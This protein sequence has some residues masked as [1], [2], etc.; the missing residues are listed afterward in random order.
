MKLD[1]V[2]TIC[3]YCGT[4]CGLVL[5]V[6][7]GKVI[8]TYPDPEHPVS[9]GT[10]CIKGWS[11]HEFIH[12][13]ERLKMPLL[14]SKGKFQ[15]ISWDQA[16]G[17]GADKLKLVAQE[18]G[19]DAVAGL[20]SAKCT[21]EENYLFQKLIRAAFKT[22]NVDHCARLCHGPT[23][24]AMSE[25]LGS[26]AMTNSIGDFVGADC[27]LMMGSNAA[28]THPI[29]MGEIYK[30]K[31]QGAT[32]IAVDPRQTEVA[33]NADI[34]LDIKPGA[35]IPLVCGMMRHI[36]DNSL[37]ARALISERTEGFEE[38][39]GYLK[40]WSVERASQECGIDQDLLR[41]VSEIYAKANEASIV[42]CMGVTQHACGTANV[43]AICDLAMLC[44][45]VGKEHSGICPLRGQNNVQGACDMGA[46]PNVYPGYQGVSD[47]QVREKFWKA[48]G[49][50][51]LSDKPGLTLTEITGS[52]GKGIRALYIMAEN[53]LLS[54]PDSNHVIE[55]LKKLDFLIVQDI[56]LTE[57]AQIADLVLPGACF[58]EKTGTYTNTE[59]RIQLIRKAIGP[60][61]D[62]KDD[63]TIICMLGKALG[64]DFD[65]AD[66]SDVMDEIAS[67]TYIY[68]GVHFHRLGVNGLQWPCPKDD[69]PGTRFLHK[70]NF[71]RGKGLFVIPEYKPPEEMPDNSYPYILI[72]GRMFSHY[73]TGTMTRRSSF[74]NR[75]V[76]V[77]YVE[78]NPADATKLEIREGDSIRVSTRRGSIV[79]TTRITE[80]VAAGSVFTPF[81]FKEAPANALTIEALDPLSKI[82]EFKLCAANVEK[83]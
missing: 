65:Y 74:L 31:D 7:D 57:T 3:P 17:I 53:P 24:A 72:T 42:F 13:P 23:A 15:E 67:L 18:H 43:F 19:G 2:K 30:A 37:E 83:M 11:A 44:G 59:R 8:G 79:T 25:A 16:I 47:P 82:P 4:G 55:S 33:K 41:K 76:D 22:N 34:H 12:H 77:P 73:H 27:I 10:L 46:L 20:S 50:A 39:N 69:H 78:I 36:I 38:L 6:R 54:D 5:Q 61:G 51:E 64:L 63:F 21:N 71:T 28:E 49:A 32:L 68:S 45:H 66:P 29:I 60:P 48:W 26:G 9:K 35:D 75:E 40:T 52:A 81:H 56:F 80:S 70:G 58:A 14:K 1:F 62:A